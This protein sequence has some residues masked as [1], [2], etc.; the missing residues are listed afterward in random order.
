MN[1][2]VEMPEASASGA[3]TYVRIAQRVFGQPLLVTPDV[4]ET[5]GNFLRSR[6][7]GLRPEAS[8]F[9][10]TQ[11]IDRDGRPRGFRKEGPVG[12]VTITGELVNR[13]AWL[14]ASSGL[15]SY[16]GIAHQVR[17]AA[18]DPDV[19]SIV[20][21]FD[22]P[23][24]EAYG[25]NDTARSLRTL[26][27]GKR[28]VAVV[29][30]VAASA[31]Y[32]LASAADEI[33]IAESGI[34]GSIGVVLVHADRSAALEKMGVKVTVISE[35]YLKAIGHP[36]APLSEIA[37]TTLRKHVSDVMTSFVKLVADHR[38]GLTEEIIRAYQSGVFRGQ[39]AVDA[40]LADKVGTFDQVVA[41]LTSAA[42]STRGT[43]Q[44]R[45]SL[46]SNEQTTDTVSKSDMD[47]AVTKA[48]EDGK[49]AGHAA[50]LQEGVAKGAAEAATRIAAILDHE[51]ANGREK[52]ARHLAF[53]SQMS[54][55]DAIATLS[56]SAIEKPEGSLSDQMKTAPD[57]NLG[58]PP[59][60]GGGDGKDKLT[61]RER[62]KL[63]AER[64]LGKKSAA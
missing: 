21:D 37:E 23:G 7:E 14:G 24:G 25:M 41:D 49:A 29:N 1:D 27:S 56:A 28:M 38:P 58:K 54:A 34:A 5:V 43:S 51:N 53:K 59:A 62:G 39:D 46:M 47:K 60:A 17:Q 12:I 19:T 16:E 2:D 11:Q 3:L 10:G 18:S 57:T 44:N 13:G 26:A 8:R 45:S 33:V 48:A 42:K 20:L 31:A 9:V 63:I 15:T 4:A 61:A 36:F 55:D 22:S 52:L 32:G 30:A 6:M 40:K 35:G 64:A 50:G